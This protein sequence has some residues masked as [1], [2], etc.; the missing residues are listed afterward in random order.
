[1]FFPDKKTGICRAT[2][3]NYT[4][5]SQWFLDGRVQEKDMG[6]VAPESDPDIKTM[7]EAGLN[8]VYAKNS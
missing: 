4:T 3:E 8:S 7:S 6:A 1:M 2:L 5:L